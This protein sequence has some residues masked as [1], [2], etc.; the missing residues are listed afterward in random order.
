[1]CNIPDYGTEEV[2]DTALA[3]ILGLFRGTLAT[4]ARLAAGDAVQGADAIA[5]CAGASV[6]R[7]RGATL[8]LVGLGRIG[9]AT[10]VR[11]KAFGFDVVFYD[12]YR[13]DGA[14]K[15]LG[16]RRAA[17][18]GELAAESTCL[19]LHCNC[20]AS[21]AGLVDAAL[22]AQLPPG[23]LLVNTARGELVDETALAAA[24]RSGHLAAAAL[25]VHAWSP[26]APARRARRRAEPALHAAPR[27]VLARGAPRDA[28]ERR[29]RR[30]SRLRGPGAPQH[31][32]RAAPPAAHVRRRA[33]PR[34]FAERRA[35]ALTSFDG[36]VG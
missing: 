3:L 17:S 2:A 33:R 28:T 18:L 7:V 30:T 25:D 14:D 6:R 26:S 4:S 9:T 21:T 24:L 34:V 36:K 10:A 27:L 8:G 1:M 20:D 35:P 19:S 15:A 29:R 31:C 22:L 23:A 11:A 16:I 5:A 13:D 32:Q 12:P